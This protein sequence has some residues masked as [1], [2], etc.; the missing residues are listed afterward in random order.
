MNPE[1]R[2]LVVDDDTSITDLLS[3]LLEVEGY[4]VMVFNSS[5]DVLYMARQF[6]PDLVILDIM[7][8]EIDGYDVCRYFKSDPQ[9]QLSRIVILTA[10][11]TSNT[12]Q[13]CY[14][15]GA[16]CFLAKPF[17]IDELRAVVQV[18]LRSKHMQDQ[19]LKEARDLSML[20]PVTRCYSWKY[21]ERRLCDELNRSE[22]HQ[23]P[24]SFVLLDLDR[25]ELVNARHGFEF[26]N[27]VLL[28]LADGIRQEVRESDVFGRYQDSFLL[29]LPETEAEGAKV[30]ADRL[31]GVVSRLEFPDRKF[32][33]NATI[34]QNTVTGG[35]PEI[36]LANLEER[37][38]KAQSRRL[39]KKPGL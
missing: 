24:L 36:I 12:R 32:S 13:D 1:S 6:L 27:K 29:L 30:A 21:L 31:E 4:K 3:D 35:K 11:E 17:E 34:V 25:F 15:A 19:L 10:R 23:R 14:K 26:G 7:M 9:L 5:K 33:I 2:V 8:P 18:H 39:G 38:R 22:R 28:S 16:D 37:L 20:D